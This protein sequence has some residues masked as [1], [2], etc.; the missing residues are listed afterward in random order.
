M[1]LLD[2]CFSE[3]CLHEGYTDIR[4]DISFKYS[5]QQYGLNE[6]KEI[7]TFRKSY[8][9]GTFTFSESRPF[10]LHERGHERLIHPIVFRDRVVI[11]CFCKYVLL[12]KLT[13]Y[14]IY[15]NCASL[16][17]KGI[18]K[19]LDR[20]KVHLKKYFFSE[21]TN[22]GYIFQ[23]DIRKFFDNLR[24]DEILKMV[25]PYLDDEELAFFALI[26][27]E[28]E[29]DVSYMT[30]EEYAGCMD[31]T[32]NSLEYDAKRYKKTGEKMMPKSVGIGSEASQIIGLFYLHRVDNYIKIVKGFKYYA[33][34]M[35]DFYIIHKDKAVLKD[36]LEE[37]KVKYKEVGLEINEKK[38]QINKLDKPITFLKTIYTLTDTGKVIM[39]KSNGT[40]KRERV[41][42][43]KF[44]HK[45]ETREFTYPMIQNQ[46]SSW[47]GTITRKRGKK[48]NSKPMFK[49][50]RQVARM[51]KLYN[52]LFIEPFIRSSYYAGCKGYKSIRST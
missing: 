8:A 42:L 52:E 22:E 14:L 51:D 45:L 36:L 3:G 5:V 49:N 29:I 2:T 6:L 32:F 11:H 37:L 27:K 46:Y 48:K 9:D 7:G 4:G 35:D 18:D 43:K 20:F 24:H 28:N 30:D 41:K 10:R 19:S 40:F 50:Y 33:R 17:G 13:P 31:K 34:Y 21:G 23:G 16:K 44:A 38:T 25:R 1:S 39:R 26:L 15:D 12:P 47:R